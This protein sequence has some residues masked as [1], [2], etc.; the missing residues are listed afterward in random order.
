MGGSGL[1]LLVALGCSRRLWLRF[2][3]R[4]AM[5]VSIW[6]LEVVFGHLGGVPVESLFDQL[7]AMILENRQ[8]SA[9]FAGERGA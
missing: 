6:G 5:K 7:K 9:G 8:A 4:Q 3:E 2:C 1:A